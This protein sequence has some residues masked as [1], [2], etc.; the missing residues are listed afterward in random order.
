MWLAIVAVRNGGPP[1]PCDHNREIA[2][3]QGVLIG[4]LARTSVACRFPLNS[5][6]G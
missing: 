5:L 3:G 1:Q 4:N 2:G 6:I